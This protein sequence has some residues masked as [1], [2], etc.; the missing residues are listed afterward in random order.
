MKAVME[1]TLSE[2][3][4]K[5]KEA[6]MILI[7][8][9]EDFQ[10]DWDIL[11]DNRR[12]QEIERETEGREEYRW[13][14]PFLQKMSLEQYPD[15]ALDRA[16]EALK[17]AIDG[18]NYFILSIAMDDCVYQHGLREDRIVAACGGFRNMQCDHNCSGVI[19]AFDEENYQKIKSYFKKEISLQ[20]LPPEPTCD[21]CG[22]KKRFNQ[23]GVSKYA[24]EGYLAQWQVYTKWLQGTVNKKTCVIELGA[25]MQFPGIIR[26]PFEKIVSYN[27]KSFLYRIHPTLYHLGESVGERG[28][29][30]KQKPVT[31]LGNGFVK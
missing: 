13:I 3:F 9:G 25:G 14:V 8:I 24:E 29:G 7:G 27:Q 21:Q 19:S 20:D 15:A 2:M 4:A 28:A 12:Y 22:Q 30:I 1:H 17:E 11:L 5:C 26:W 10:Y 18:K 16:Y 23:L 31:F 6:E